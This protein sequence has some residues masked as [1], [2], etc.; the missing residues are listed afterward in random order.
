MRTTSSLESM[1]SVL[2]R[3]F[4]RRPNIYKFIDGL[5]I[6]EFAKYKQLLELSVEN[7]DAR[8][9]K[10][11]KR[12][13]DQ[14][15]DD[16]IKRVTEDLIKRKINTSQF[17]EKFS[18][19]G[20]LLP[21]E[22]NFPNQMLAVCFSYLS[23]FWFFFYFYNIIIQVHY[24]CSPPKSLGTVVEAAIPNQVVTCE[25]EKAMPPPVNKIASPKKL[26]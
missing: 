2:G 3:F 21:K 15:R 16:K 23:L 25:S 5:K 14:E 10:T 17:L 18:T 9:R 19:D 24:Q 26:N 7:E 22:G 8:K 1:N 6:Y 13:R 11:R 4:L 20:S 12:K